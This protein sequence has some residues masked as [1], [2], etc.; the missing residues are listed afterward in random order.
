MLRWV[1]PD[2]GR[3]EQVE[4]TRAPMGPGQVRL[5]M[6]AFALNFRD[7]RMVEGAYDP[8]LARPM[9]PLSDGVGEV[10]EVGDGVTR[11]RVGD[12]AVPTFSPTWIGGAPDWDA[13]RQTRGGTVPGVLAEEIVVG[14]EEIVVPPAHLTDAEAATLPCAALTAWSALEGV[15]PGETVLT[16]GSGGVSVF[17][18]QIAKLHGARVIATTSSEVKAERLRTLGADAVVR[19]DTDPRWGRT[20]RAL[21]DGGVDRVIEVGGSGTLAQSLDAV[22]PG[23]SI[24]LIGVLSGGADPLSIFP[25]FM[26][27]VRVQGVFVGSR[28]QFDAMN[29][30][31]G[32]HRLRPV[33]DRVFAFDEAPAAFAYQRSGAHL[34][35]VV[36]SGAPGGGPTSPPNRRDGSS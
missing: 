7:L 3:L 16:L 19:Y 30:A 8:R 17:A 36:V 28:Q 26:K 27:A 29:R 15:A 5:R 34:G 10:I 33:V 18:I 2:W 6:R 20:A 21:A 22:R 12:R 32:R 35:K 9:V 1:V 23:A 14:Q 31:I 4:G 25:M 24:A 13:V 11:V